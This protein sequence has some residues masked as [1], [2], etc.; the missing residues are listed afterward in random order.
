MWKKQKKKIDVRD[1]IK[2]EKKRKREYRRLKAK[3]SL[4]DDV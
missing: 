4:K 1:F 2:E 3:T